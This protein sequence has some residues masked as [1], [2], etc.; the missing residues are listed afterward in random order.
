MF[1]RIPVKILTI[2]F[3]LTILSLAACH[4]PASLQA[5]APIP[6]EGVDPAPTQEDVS[7]DNA[8]A[9]LTSTDFVIKGSIQ[10]APK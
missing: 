6:E 3:A 5:L 8:N 2:F 10:E 4:R 1:V 7:T 9:P